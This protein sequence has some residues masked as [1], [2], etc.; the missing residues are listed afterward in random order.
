MNIQVMKEIIPEMLTVEI[1]DGI[2]AEIL[3]RKQGN[4][5]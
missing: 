4:G 3:V 5:Y 1:A 2:S